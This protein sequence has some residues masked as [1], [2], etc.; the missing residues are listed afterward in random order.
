MFVL[1]GKLR[2]VGV[3]N[4]YGTVIPDSKDPSYAKYAKY[5]RENRFKKEKRYVT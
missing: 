1:A 5:Q 2:I 3:V 4:E